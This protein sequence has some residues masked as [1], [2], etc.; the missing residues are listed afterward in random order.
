M[1][2]KMMK[3]TIMIKVSYWGIINGTKTQIR[4]SIYQNY[5]ETLMNK[6][7]QILNMK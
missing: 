4:T 7:L 3:I 2:I 6:I 1:K 5:K